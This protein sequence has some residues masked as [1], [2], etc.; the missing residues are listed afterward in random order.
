MYFSIFLQIL[1]KNYTLCRQKSLEYRQIISLFYQQKSRLSTF[2][3]IYVKALFLK[4]GISMLKWCI[5]DEDGFAFPCSSK[6]S[7][8][9]IMEFLWVMYNRKI[10]VEL[11]NLD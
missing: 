9:V 7:A 5:I 2:Y 11:L 8:E 10:K 3:P 4:E 1:M 6:E